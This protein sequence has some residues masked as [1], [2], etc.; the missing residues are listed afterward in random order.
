[1]MGYW[2]IAGLV[3]IILVLVFWPRREYF[4]DAS[5]TGQ[6]IVLRACGSMTRVAKVNLNGSG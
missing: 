6:M 1:M 3:L 5:F 2:L 4:A